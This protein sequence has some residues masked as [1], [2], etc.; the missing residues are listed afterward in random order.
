MLVKCMRCPRRVE[1][2]DCSPEDAE[3]WPMLCEPCWH[4][5]NE[6]RERENP[7]ASDTYLNWK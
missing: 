1:V 6:A 5:D 2:G 4:K 7:E 3:R